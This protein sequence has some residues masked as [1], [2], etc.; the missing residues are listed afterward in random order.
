MSID[1]RSTDIPAA[2]V[3]D[4]CVVGA[5]AAGMAVVRRLIG[6]QLSVVLVESGG[7]QL[8]AETQSLCRGENAGLPYFDLETSRLRYLGG[9]LNHWGGNSVPLTSIDFARRDWVPQSG[10]PISKDDLDPYYALANEWLGL[11]AY[12][13]DAAKLRPPGPPYLGAARDELVA[14]L[15]RVAEPMR[16]PEESRHALERADNV[17]LL[18]NANAVEIELSD[19]GAAVTAIALSTLDG[20]TADLRARVVVLACGGIETPRLLL[21]SNRQRV[22]GVGNDNGLVGRY[23]TEHPHVAAALVTRTVSQDWVSAYP[24]FVRDGV[25]M[26]VG[27]GLSEAAQARERV[28]NFSAVFQLAR[29]PHLGEGYVA[30]KRLIRYLATREERKPLSNYSRAVLADLPSV[31]SGLWGSLTGGKNVRIYARSE[32]APN[33]DSRVELTGERDRLGLPKV[34]LIWCLGA[35]DRRTLRVGNEIIGAELKRLGVG[36]VQFADWL[37]SD[38]APWPPNLDGGDHHMGTTRMADDPK[39]GVVDRNCRVHGVSNLYVAGPSTFPTG[40]YANPTLTI[41]ALAARLADHLK[42]QFVET[43]GRRPIQANGVVARNT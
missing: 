5:G 39:Q 17:T 24:D 23:F 22:S 15:W 10:W 37:Q 43:G 29:D 12:D 3:Y 26:R 20:K 25:A 42:V 28:L 1:F 36:E 32:Q 9:S 40:G 31:I 27:V 16:F 13:Y 18:L 11:G 38:D 14:R 30:L 19:N 33:P 7:H 35:L 6:S 8:E 4:I 41:L 34:R 2:I 21:C